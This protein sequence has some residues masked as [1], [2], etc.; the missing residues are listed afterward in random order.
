M[1]APVKPPVVRTISRVEPILR[2]D[3][4]MHTAIIKKMDVDAAERYLVTG[5]DDKTVRVWS[6][7]DGRLLRVLRPPMGKG[8]EGKVYAVAISPHG[9]TVAVGG[10]TSQSGFDNAIYLFNRATGE[11]RQRITGLPNRILHL[12]YSP[13]GSRLVA[14]L[15][16][17]GI[18]L[19]Q[20]SDYRLQAQDTNYNLASYWAEFDSNGRLVTT[21]KDGYIR[22][23]NQNLN[24]LAKR[25]ALGGRSPYA[26]RFS[27]AGDKIAVGF[28][29]STQINVLSS[30]DLILLYSPST[31]D[32]NNASLDNLAWSQ[33]GNW[34]Y[35][36]GRYNSKGKVHILRW[37]QA[38]QGR[39]T[40][41][42]ASSNAIMGIHALRK[43]RIVFGSAEPYFGIFDANGQKIRAR[44]VDI[45]DFRAIYDGH[46]L[47]SKDGS[48]VQFGYEYGGKKPARF[49]LKKRTLILD[50]LASSKLIAPRLKGLRITNW[51]NSTR[52]KLNGK[53]LSLKEDETVRSLAITANEQHFL[54]GTEWFLRFFDKQ[55]NL[56]WKTDTPSVAWGVN[57]AGNG[58]VAIAAFGD[59]T[60]RW[61]RLRDGKELLAFFPHKDGKRWIV[62]TPQGYYAASSGGETLIGWQIN[63]GPDQAADFFPAAHFRDNYYR[64]ALVAN[65]LDSLKLAPK[66][67]QRIRKQLPPVVTLLSPQNGATFSD[68][69]LKLRYRIRSPSNVRGIK[70]LID[71]RPL[72]KKRGLVRQE[73]SSLQITVPSRDVKVSLIA[74][75]KYAASE[76]ATIQLRWQGGSQSVNNLPT[77]YVLAVGVSKYESVQKLKYADQDAQDLAQLFRRQ[78]NKG[79]Y[80]DIQVNLLKN[81]N[82]EEILDGLHWIEQQTTQNDV[83]VIAFA[84]HGVNDEK[85]LYY[86]LPR[87]V[88]IKQLKSTGVAYHDIK[89]TMAS[90]RGKALFLIDTCHSGNI[91]GGVADVNQV[92]NDLSMAENG[93]VVFTA[94]TGTQQ[95]LEHSRWQNGAFTEALLE[96]LK[97]QA[98]YIADGMISITELEL[99]LSNRV[100]ELAGQ[101]QTPTTAKPQT[102]VDFPIVKF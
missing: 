24:L 31:P 79:L 71:G 42:P 30:K 57:I 48:I 97:G 44:H 9:E 53:A 36:G 84:G 14:S 64:P 54:L 15:K 41:W 93:V 7:S 37:S 55:G 60:L 16:K 86:F 50:P 22:L 61:Y 40:V 95:S 51:Q 45:A 69:K 78:K 11:L 80:R 4:G 18:R 34:L 82:K 25:K 63:Q 52:P 13:D 56:Q 99:Y 58:K 100:K 74:E 98:D 26:A 19:Y 38:G 94:S 32:I 5:S 49:S 6:L 27:P 92:A 65:V 1:E 85:G 96:G 43:G 87:D 3:T 59:G 33:D 76:A 89:D 75:N 12:A 101:T 62:W 17:G 2:I 102:I 83:A 91:L 90:L 35:A 28:Q 39:Y 72:L 23:Y 81:A 77:L 70:V 8:H 68:T 67:Q 73:E 29:D 88:N 47:I 10:W 46:F 20:S 66:K 21:C